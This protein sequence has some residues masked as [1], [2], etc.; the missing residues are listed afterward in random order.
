MTYINLSSYRK[1][2]NDLDKI[3]DKNV[4]RYLGGRRRV[5]L[6]MENTLKSNPE[7]FGLFNNGITIVVS[8]WKLS[9]DQLT[10]D[11]PHIVNGCQTS[12][13]IWTLFD[14]RLACGGNGRNPELEHWERRVSEA[15]VVTKIVRVGSSGEGLLK[16]I[17]RYTNS[18]NAVQEKDFLALSKD[19]SDW[20]REM[21]DRYDIYLEIQRGGWDSQKA[22]QKRNINTKRY[23]RH[24]NSADLIKVYGA[25]WLEAAGPAFAK[26]PP[27]LP[28]GAIFEKMMAK[29]TE[30]EEPFGVDDLYA[31]YLLQ[32]AGDE[33]KF[34]RQGN[35][36]RRQT[37]FLFYFIVVRL[38]KYCMI[39][40]GISVNDRE[41]SQSIIKVLKNPDAYE[42]LIT[43]ASSVIDDYMSRDFEDNVFKEPLMIEKFNSDLNAFLKIDGLGKQGQSPNLYDRIHMAEALLNHRI[44]GTKPIELI[45]SVINHDLNN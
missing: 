30:N 5:N 42:L 33:Q 43:T 13:T 4:R 34:G 29:P 12:R 11:D 37:R 8:D 18:Q 7:N 10:L 15:A 23:D 32:L 38:L 28:G 36:A 31:A 39:R 40:S 26:N 21:S 19:F 22:F 24:V 17:T 27:F 2:T 9:D 16:E 35:L 44:G 14:K 6:G 1:E 3:Y 20:Q 25:G 45:K 41:V